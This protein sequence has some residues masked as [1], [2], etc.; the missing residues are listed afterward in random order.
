[1]PHNSNE[2]SKKPIM[3]KY[4]V[5]ISETDNKGQI[6]KL[7]PFRRE[8]LLGKAAGSSVGRYK[9]L[10]SGKW[11]VGCDSPEM[12]TRLSRCTALGGIPVT[13][14]IPSPTVEGVVRGV[15]LDQKEWSLFEAHVRKKPN[16]A[17]IYRLKNRKGQPSTAVKV[18]FRAEKLPTE[19]IVAGQI[20]DVVPFR[21]FARRCTKCQKLGHSKR[22]C[23]NDTHVCARCGTKGHG[24]EGCKA[25]P[26]CVNCHGV[27]SSNDP[28]CPER[29]I[30]QKA[31]E[32]RAQVYMPFSAAI[33]WAR[34][35]QGE[36]KMDHPLTQT[37][38]VIQDH[39]D[40]REINRKSEGT[41]PRS[42]AQIVRKNKLTHRKQ[43]KEIKDQNKA[44]EPET[45]E[46]PPKRENNKQTT[47]ADVHVGPRIEAVIVDDI[48]VEGEAHA[49]AP[50]QP[51][52]VKVPIRKP[53]VREAPLPRQ[54]IQEKENANN[55]SLTEEQPNY[56]V[57]PASE[58]EKEALKAHEQ[59]S[60]VMGQYGEPE[61]LREGGFS[62]LRALAKWRRDGDVWAFVEAIFHP[63]PA[64]Q[65]TKMLELLLISAGL[66]ADVSS[67]FNNLPNI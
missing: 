52:I 1:V 56:E 43:N 50:K 67:E 8:E 29:V 64:P 59:F 22:F 33:T 49:I 24:A 46:N 9:R 28:K 3:F 40:K 30:W 66:M 55:A 25:T 58:Q 27:H 26:R 2:Q 18:I 41:P 39:W 6:G 35:T 48:M 21:G 10:Q 47:Q 61:H 23:K 19:L 63:Q 5:V 20:L 7:G 38:P 31:T 13:C 12:Q 51:V 53:S 37:V 11:V 16:I 44:K 62:V 4:P 34:T 60:E 15:P 45:A 42:Y 14:M 65:K 57:R 17:A 36:K 54:E 32:E